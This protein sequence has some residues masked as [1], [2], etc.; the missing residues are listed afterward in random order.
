MPQTDLGK[1]KGMCIDHNGNIVVIEPHYQRVNHFSPEGKLL[2][3]WGRAGTNRGEFTLPRSVAVN[4]RGDIFVTEYTR[5]DRVQAFSAPSPLNGERAGVRGE[6]VHWT[7]I[8][9]FG[10]SGSGSGEFNR[11]EGIDID[12]FDRICVADSCN[13]RVQVFAPDGKWLRAYGRPGNNLAEMS[14]PYDVRVDAAGYQYVC[15]FGNSRVQIFDAHDKPVEILGGPGASPG[16]FSNPWSSA[17]DS[18]GNLFVCDSGN[19]R[20]QK[21]IRR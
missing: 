16:Q 5:V 6:T 1:P 19:H 7:P 11:A 12:R 3:Q 8:L 4:S 20:V 13:H 17:L 10:Q 18:H 21:F 14:Y 15:E 9:L 2:A